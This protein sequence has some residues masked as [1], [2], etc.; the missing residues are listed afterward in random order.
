MAKAPSALSA[1]PGCRALPSC[2]ASTMEAM[3]R[4]W[5]CCGLTAFRPISRSSR[6]FH[7]PWYFYTLRCDTL[8]SDNWMKRISVVTPC[9]NEEDNVRSCYEELKRVFDEQLSGY[10]REHIFVDNASTD[11]TMAE[12]RKLA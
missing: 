7:F 9:Y 5:G 6:Y 8:Y 11:R 1:G 12:L 2:T 4:H 10:E 3:S